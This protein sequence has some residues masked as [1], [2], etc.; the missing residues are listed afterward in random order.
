MFLWK[1]GR[2]VNSQTISFCTANIL[3]LDFTRVNESILIL[4][5]I[6]ETQMQEFK[7]RMSAE[8]LNENP[9]ESFSLLM[10]SIYEKS[11]VLS[12]A[13]KTEK[14]TGGG[15]NVFLYS[16]IDLVILGSLLLYFSKKGYPS[17]AV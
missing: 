2:F 7:F 12:S 11:L 3:Y 6:L 16:L 15:L 9:K 10:H 14:K 5:F 1:R 17:Y 8:N 13:N 4:K